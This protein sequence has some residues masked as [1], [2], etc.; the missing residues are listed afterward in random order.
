[1]MPN[2]EVR[3]EVKIKNPRRIAAGKRNRA[4]AAPITDATRQK[5]RDAIFA[6]KPWLRST[7][8]RSPAGKAKT[9]KNAAK[10]SKRSETDDLIRRVREHVR[11]LAELRR[12]AYVDLE[13]VSLKTT[14]QL[15]SELQSG[16]QDAYGS[17][18]KRL[19]SSAMRT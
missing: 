13:S 9:S 12:T 4:R 6:N 2:P 17:S 5:L 10:S 16:L 7:G 11:L 15:A 1:M 3:E 8:P 14:D 18:V 19:A